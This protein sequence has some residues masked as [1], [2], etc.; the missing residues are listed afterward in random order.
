MEEMI[1]Y[2]DETDVYDLHGRKVSP[3]HQLEKGIYII[4]GKKVVIR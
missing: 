4:G 3:R 1:V 2:S